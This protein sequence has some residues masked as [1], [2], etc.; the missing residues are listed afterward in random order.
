MGLFDADFVE[1]IIDIAESSGYEVKKEGSFFLA[2]LIL[3]TE[4]ADL[5]VFV[6]PEVLDLMAQMLE[7][8][9]GMIIRRCLDALLVFWRAIESEG[10]PEEF[11]DAF[12]ECDMAENLTK[13]LE[14]DDP[15]IREKVSFL[16]HRL[17]TVESR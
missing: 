11:R 3:F 16:L 7:C 15:I 8:S 5:G 14:S 2:T 6:R 4:K 17:E 12:E 13:L 9:I 10:A 1:A